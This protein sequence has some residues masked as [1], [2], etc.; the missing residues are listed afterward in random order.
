MSNEVLLF[1]LGEVGSERGVR[2]EDAQ[3]DDDDHQDEGQETPV[4]AS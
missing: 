4:L 1:L 3:A 2:Q